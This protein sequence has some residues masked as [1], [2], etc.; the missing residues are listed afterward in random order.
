[1][2]NSEYFLNMFLDVLVL[3]FLWKNPPLRAFPT[4]PLPGFGQE[5]RQET[6]RFK[7]WAR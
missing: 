4:F 7:R 3:F 2:N 6:E 1:M 5:W